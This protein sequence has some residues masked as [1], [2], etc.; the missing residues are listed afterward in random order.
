M[1]V[2]PVLGTPTVLTTTQGPIHVRDL[3]PAGTPNGHT[4][5]MVPGFLASGDLWKPVVPDL[6]RAG[7]RVITMDPPVG[8]HPEPMHPDADL[9]PIGLARIQGEVIEQLDLDGVTIV[10]NDS[11]CAVT[12]LLLTEDFPA[13]KRVGRVVFATG[14]FFEHFPPGPFVPLLSLPKVPGALTAMTKA[15]RSNLVWQAPTSFGW[16]SNDPLPRDVRDAFL[17]PALGSKEIRRDVGKVLTGI[18]KS[19]TLAAAEKFGTVDVPVTFLWAGADKF[20]PV[21]DAHKAAALLPDA[22]VVEIEGARTFVMWDAP[23]RVVDEIVRCHT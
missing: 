20:F 10:A 12:Q 8:A 11:G 3:A 22:E 16:L 18:D 15:L 23:Q 1:P 17:G 14:D 4:L 19:Y 5:L 9:T 13:A 21:S 6:A 2:D 7:F